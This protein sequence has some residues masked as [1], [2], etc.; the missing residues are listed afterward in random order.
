MIRKVATW[1]VK[2]NSN[3]TLEEKNTEGLINDN[4][5]YCANQSLFISKL[6]Y[7]T[8]NLRLYKPL[9]RPVVTHGNET[10]KIKMQSNR[11]NYI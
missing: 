5:A 9:I 2:V 8:V 10:L 1:R 3:N 11:V 6:I 4:K 7:K